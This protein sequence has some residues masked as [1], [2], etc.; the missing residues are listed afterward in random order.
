MWKLCAMLTDW[1][2]GYSFFISKWSLYFYLVWFC[3][4]RNKKSG[5]WD[6]HIRYCN[7]LWKL[8][9]AHG[10]CRVSFIFVKVW[11]FFLWT[12]VNK[13]FEIWKM[14]LLNWNNWISVENWYIYSVFILFWNNRFLLVNNHK[15]L[16]SLHL[17]NTRVYL[18]DPA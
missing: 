13:P 4:R 8:N 17:Q 9:V 2:Q 7:C 10:T 14:C 16:L 11:K 12:T 6:Y 1:W 3:F 15:K 5:Y 18:M